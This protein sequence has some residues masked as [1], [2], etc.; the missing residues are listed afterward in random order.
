ALA[1]AEGDAR[2]SFQAAQAAYLQWQRLADAADRIG[3]NARL[4]EKA[5]RYGEGQIGDLLTARR[6]A[7]EARLAAIQARFDASEMRYRLLLDA[8]ELWPLDDEESLSGR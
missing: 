2:R 5:W 7:A 3:D 1:K 6:Q 8:H 4:L